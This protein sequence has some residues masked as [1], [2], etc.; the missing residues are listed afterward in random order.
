MNKTLILIIFCIPT[1][2]LAQDRALLFNQTH[3][4]Q[5]LMQNPGMRYEQTDFHIGMPGLSSVYASFGNT[6]FTFNDLI[7][8][9]DINDNIDAILAQLSPNGFLTFTQSLDLINVGWHHKSYYF[10]A[11][12]YQEL[13]ANIYY[14]RDMLDLVFKGNAGENRVYG[15]DDLNFTGNMQTVFH[16]GINKKIHGKLFMGT[17][18]K[19]YTSNLNVKSTDNS[20]TFASV[21]NPTGNDGLLF[22]NIRRLDLT[23]QSTGLDNFDEMSISDAAIGS[24]LGLGLD[25]GVSYHISRQAEIT[26]SILDFGL[27]RFNKNTRIDRVVGSYYYTGT[28]FNFPQFD[29]NEDINDYFQEVEEEVKESIKTEESDRAYTYFQPVKFNL[30]FSFSFGGNKNDCNC[31]YDY[32]PVD[33]NQKLGVQFFSLLRPKHFQNSLIGFYERSF[34]NVFYTKFMLGFDQFNKTNYGLGFGLDYKGI[35]LFLNFDRINDIEN[36]YYANAFSV[37][38]GLSFKF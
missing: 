5:A 29:A 28:Q 38:T 26:A 27:I 23:F 20:G 6:G 10:T 34:G 25:F 1:F 14:P 8:D 3:N 4:P 18:V 36:I 15:F 35:N 31:A 11:G 22:Q 2:L 32:N 21:Y 17:R 37:Q 19:L 9:N 24:N 33:G 16:F 7:N 30:A 12:I 13:D